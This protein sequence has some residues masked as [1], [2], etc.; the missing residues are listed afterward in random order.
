MF[1]N[2]K[3]KQNCMEDLMWFNII[4]LRPGN[5][6]NVDKQNVFPLVKKRRENNI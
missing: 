3:G 4:Q 1:Y 6:K 5:P 2:T